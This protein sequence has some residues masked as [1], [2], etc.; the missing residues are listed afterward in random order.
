MFSK[1]KIGDFFPYLIEYRMSFLLKSVFWNEVFA[2]I[3]PQ[4]IKVDLFELF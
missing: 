1:Y 3:V 2:I 4:D